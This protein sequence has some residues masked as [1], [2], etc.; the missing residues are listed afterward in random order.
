MFVVFR[1]RARWSDETWQVSVDQCNVRL[2]LCAVCQLLSL[3][4]IVHL[5]ALCCLVCFVYFMFL[6]VFSSWLSLVVSTSWRPLHSRRSTVGP[7]CIF[8]NSF[9]TIRL[10]EHF[11]LLLLH[12]FTDHLCP[13]SLPLGRSTTLHLKFGTVSGHPQDQRTLSIFLG[14]A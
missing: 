11:D 14:I 1:C 9:K 5:W 13:P 10:P 12:C 7:H 6:R 2:L 4:P 3:P 8:T